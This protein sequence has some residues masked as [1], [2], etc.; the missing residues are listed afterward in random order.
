MM[1][2]MLVG[3]KVNPQESMSPAYGL[4]ST[5]KGAPR[6]H[7]LFCLFYLQARSIR[8]CESLCILCIPLTVCDQSKEKRPSLLKLLLVQ[9]TGIGHVKE[10][11]AALETS[12]ADIVC[13]KN[14]THLAGRS[15]LAMPRASCR[16]RA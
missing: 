3:G 5:F 7:G 15:P 6:S 16:S 12:S 2:Q 10:V 8:A 4:L 14:G 13:Y 9:M 1:Y 11:P